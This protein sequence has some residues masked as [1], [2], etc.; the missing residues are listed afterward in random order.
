MSAETVPTTEKNPDVEPA[1]GVATQCSDK[2]FRYITPR[3]AGPFFEPCE[4]PDCF[5]DS[6]PVADETVVVAR[7]RGTGSMHAPANR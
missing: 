1:C 5:A 6:E 3:Q 2:T 7:G 4:N